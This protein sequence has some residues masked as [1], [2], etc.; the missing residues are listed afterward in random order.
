[1]SFYSRLS[2]YFQYLYTILHPFT[3]GGGAVVT[4][5]IGNAMQFIWRK[6]LGILTEPSCKQLGRQ[7]S[8]IWLLPPYDGE[9]KSDTMKTLLQKVQE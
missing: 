9:T 1:M 4:V 8:E 6:H 2:E 7:Q 5:F 3:L